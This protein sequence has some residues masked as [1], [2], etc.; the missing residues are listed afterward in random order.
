MRRDWRLTDTQN[1]AI[2]AAQPEL[3]NRSRDD[4]DRAARSRPLD[5]LWDDGAEA[6]LSWRG[7]QG[8][9]YDD[10]SYESVIDDTDSRW[11]RKNSFKYSHYKDYSPSSLFRSTFTRSCYYGTLADTDL[12]N[13]AIRALRAL[14]RNANTVS[15]KDK[16]VN[17]IVQFSDGSDINGEAQKL[18]SG[19]KDQV[20]Y[21][22]PDT[23]VTASGTEEDDA[24]ID[25]LTGFVLLRVQIAQEFSVDLITAINTTTLKS[26]PM[27]IGEIIAASTAERCAELAV[28]HTDR[29]LSGMLAKSL[30][31]RLSRRTVVADWGGFAPYIGRHAKR[32]AAVREK[33]ATAP[34]S[35]ETMIGQIAYNMIDDEGQFELPTEIDEIIGRHLGAEIV[36]DGILDVCAA[37]I[38]EIRAFFVAT[39]PE[40]SG[41]LET[42]LRETI[43]EMA[44]KFDTKR[45]LNASIADANERALGACG[46]MI[47]EYARNS[48]A[49]GPGLRPE[50]MAAVSEDL[51]EIDRLSALNDLMTTAQMAIKTTIASEVALAAHPAASAGYSTAVSSSLS[52]Q[53]EIARIFQHFEQELSQLTSDGTID[54]FDANAFIQGDESLVLDALRNER[55]ALLALASDIGDHLREATRKLRDKLKDKFS[56]SVAEAASQIEEAKQDGTHD[57]ELAARVGGIMRDVFGEKPPPECAAVQDMAGAICAVATGAINAA[58]IALTKLATGINTLAKSR[59]ISGLRDSYMNCSGAMNMRTGG[60][61]PLL[62]I[63]QTIRNAVKPEDGERILGK[64][65]NTVDAVINAAS[66]ADAPGEY[67]DSIQWI[68]DAACA[69][70][71][72]A[73]ANIDAM[74]ES[75]FATSNAEIMTK[76]EELFGRDSDGD[77]IQPPGDISNVSDTTLKTLEKMAGSAGL[78]SEE[79]LDIAITTYDRKMNGGR[80]ERSAAA[81]IGEE[82]GQKIRKLLPLFEE[83]NVADEQLF[84]AAPAPNAQ[85]ALGELNQVNDEARNDPEEAYVAYIAN[86]DGA[87]PA[88]RH[89]VPEITANMR[90]M[91]RDIVAKSRQ[92]IGKIRDALEFQNGRRT[93]EVY[94]TRSGDL[95]EGGLHKLGYDCEHIWSQQTITKLPDVAVGILV[96]QSGSMS[97]ASKI[98]HAREICIVLA[99]AVKQIPGVHLHIYGHTANRSGRIDVSLYT[100]YSSTADH[101]AR[102]ADLSGL[103][104][105]V[106]QS[107]NYDGYAIKEAAKLLNMD[108]AKRKYL[109]VISDGLPHG[110]GYG[111]DPA[112]KHV[113]SVCAFVR[114]RLRI[115]LYA[116]AVGAHRGEM[117]NFEQQY[118]KANTVFVSHVAACLP[119]IVRFLR[120]A[121]QREK[122]L[123]DVVA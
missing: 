98:I 64:F 4:L 44:A 122:K 46:E 70:P 29:C 100:H 17:Y 75:A 101:A 33:I 20:I 13:K 113:T 56:Q 32:F 30:I 5:N 79:L 73:V 40:V 18:P 43:A 89:V 42:Q 72:G 121:L 21:V 49:A 91:A 54:A 111:G 48:D 76:L 83:M 116:F 10:Y 95:D 28:T 99:E 9:I 34:M 61:A 90:T 19:K 105:I 77:L 110:E 108:P 82:F 85:T 114:E 74:T 24:A 112:E 78:T 86:A 15:D 84:G 39:T 6:A 118:G 62:A 12:K 88:I 96:D 11:Y 23:L 26:L 7:Y 104:A 47:N 65:A 3:D 37:L 93:G 119:K 52:I 123:V 67:L 120:K 60:R 22:S 69:S 81:T 8:P 97:S 68:E 63:S 38:A 102:G 57:G 92:A 117:G 1:K 66:T 55:A 115:G 36:A 103:G 27:R 2:D 58:E 106:A 14:T 53:K 107:N 25:A 16:N 109:F 80:R 35:L 45:E 94:G 51:A 87:K 41:A 31:T 50:D 71:S 59:T